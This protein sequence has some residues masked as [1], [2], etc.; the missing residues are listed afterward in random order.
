MMITGG[1]GSWPC[2]AVAGCFRG[3]L[4]AGVGEATSRRP[5]GTPGLRI[6]YCPP[7]GS[8][9]RERLRGNA[10]RAIDRSTF[11]RPAE[12]TR[13]QASQTRESYAK[14]APRFKGI[15]AGNFV[16]LQS[17]VMPI[18]K[19]T[20]DQQFMEMRWR[21]LSL[22]ADLDRVQRAGSIRDDERLARL[23]RA[24]QVLLTDSGNR[25]EQVEMIFSDMSPPPAR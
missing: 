16:G 12:M 6:L 25:A 11:D 22:A 4:S 7:P 21:C 14:P 19:E 18:P 2:Q 17:P 23:R 8:L 15:L 24:I 13:A 10:C 5:T 3:R 1:Q 9:S 20:L